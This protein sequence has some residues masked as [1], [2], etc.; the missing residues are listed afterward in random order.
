MVTRFFQKAAARLPVIKLSLF[1][2]AVLAAASW[3]FLFTSE[4]ADL[5]ALYSGQNVQHTMDF[6]TELAGI[7]QENPAFLSAESW[8]HALSLTFDTLIM[9]IMAIG[10]AVIVVVLTVIPAV[11]TSSAGFLSISKKGYGL[12]LFWAVRLFYVFSRAV[13]EL[14]W[15]MLIIFILMPGILP[16]AIALAIHNLGILGK[17]CAEVIEDM[18]GRPLQ[19][20]EMSGA[21]K[22]Q[23]LIYG[24]IP[25]VFPKFIT[26]ILYRWEVIVRTTVIVGFVGAGGLGREFKLSMSWFHYTEVALYLICYVGLVF[27][28][29]LISEG[30]RKA[31]E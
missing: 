15:A 12:F 2:A 29:D 20:L 18:D 6:L 21:S 17:L 23:L 3:L 25:L 19:A 5:P 24:V 31:A 26:Y 14:L 8:K 7:E 1:L 28:A 11:K 22:A 10:F 27:L 16:G 30:L 9:S 13:P 4:G